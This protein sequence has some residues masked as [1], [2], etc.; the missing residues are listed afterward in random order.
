[1]SDYIVSNAQ[2][3][4]DIILSGFFNGFEKGFYVDVGA[5]HPD[6]LSIS[7][8]FYD[9]GWSGI[10][11]EP[12]TKLYKLLKQQR[13]RDINLN[14]GASDKPGKLTLREYPEG[15]GLSTFSKETQE[16]YQKSGSIY[17]KNTINYEDHTVEVKPLSQIFEENDVKTVHFM[18]I[19]VE[20]F[21]YNVIQGNDWN[22]YR[23]LVLC[24]EANHIAKDWRPLLEKARYE[25]VFFDGLNNYYTDSDKKEIA[26]N[27]S[28]VNT[29]L[30]DKSIIPA[31]FHKILQERMAQINQAQN[32]IVRQDLVEQNLRAEIYALNLQIVSNRR[33]RSLIK[34]LVSGINA[35]ILTQIEKLNKPRITKQAPLKLNESTSTASLLSEVQLY[36]LNQF[37][38]SNASPPLS[39]RLILGCYMAFYSTVKSTARKTL[40]YIRGTK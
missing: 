40:R 37:Y 35:A 30:L 18:N 25:L 11:I 22:K 8:Y 31:E 10:N 13:L 38:N 17:K 5:N 24:I 12:N 27:F 29:V 32:R 34:Q 21:E 33:I 20:G 39:Y 14:I 1:M 23:P 15:D 9:R 4:E 6:T 7:K 3:R 36:D 28:Y 26:Q 2:N 16:Q 19:D